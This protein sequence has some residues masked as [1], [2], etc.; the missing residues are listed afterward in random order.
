MGRYMLLLMI[1]ITSLFAD[2]D[3]ADDYKAA[4]KEAKAGQKKV[5]VFFSREDCS[6]CDEMRWTMNS[7]RN[8]SK[9]ITAHFV[10]VEIDTEFDKR[11][12]YKVYKTPTIYFLDSNAKTIGDPLDTTLGPKGFLKKLQEV[13]GTK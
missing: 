12:G 10:A 9:Y 13:D 11:E 6:K 5:I 4:V 1:A 2:I 7:D 3:W 8:V